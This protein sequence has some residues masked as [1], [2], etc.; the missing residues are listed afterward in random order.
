MPELRV[1]DMVVRLAVDDA[2]TAQEA[3]AKFAR[4]LAG[5]LWPDFVL[6]VAEQEYLI[7]RA[8]AEAGFADGQA[9]L[10]AERFEVAAARGCRRE[11]LGRAGMTAPSSSPEDF[12]GTLYDGDGTRLAGTGPEFSLETTQALPHKVLIR[13]R[14]GAEEVAVLERG[15]RLWLLPDTFGAPPELPMPLLAE[16]ADVVR[17]G[18][19]VGLA[20]STYDAYALVRDA[21]VLLLDEAWGQA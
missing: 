4:A 2:R 15:D 7:R 10:A 5:A 11:Q 8:I 9:R 21:L 6:A 14:P 1:E 19:T 20:G 16:L 13:D 12:P 3:G 17:R 18:N